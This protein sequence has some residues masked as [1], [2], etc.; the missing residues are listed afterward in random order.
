MNHNVDSHRNLTLTCREFLQVGREQWMV[1]P[2]FP[3]KAFLRLFGPLGVHARIRNTRVIQAINNID[4]PKLAQI[5]DAGCGHAY[6]SFWLARKNPQ[7][8][9][10]EIDIGNEFIQNGR[11]IAKR[12]GAININFETRDIADIHFANFYDLIFSID[13][14]EHVI[15]D[16]SVLKSFRTALKPGGRLVLHLPRRHQEHKRIFPVFKKHT[17]PDHVRDEYTAQEITDKLTQAGFTIKSLKYGF[18]PLGELAF[19]L[20]YLFW[21]YAFL[22]SLV[23]DTFPPTISIVGIF[24]YAD[25]LPRRK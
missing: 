9:F 24:G 25:R 13:V 12:I 8:T 21:E 14:L 17:T 18:G 2:D 6:A 16:M 11:Q 10:T 4:L 20:N 3:R 5:L 23:R 19:E 7:W 15:D 1:Q 22:R